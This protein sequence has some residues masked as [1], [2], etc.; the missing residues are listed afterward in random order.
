MSPL[1]R[2]TVL[3]GGGVSLAAAAG[4]GLA[5]SRESAPV[6][7]PDTTDTAPED[8]ALR[9]AALSDE[10]RLVT[11][12][13]ETAN[14]ITATEGPDASAKLVVLA[15]LNH[16][17]EHVTFLKSEAGTL[18]RAV[19]SALLRE[20]LASSLGQDD[21]QRL[22]QDP[23]PSLDPSPLQS[24][25]S[26]PSESAKPSP[27]PAPTSAR[28]SPAPSPSPSPTPPPMPTFRPP[29]AKPTT[30]TEPVRALLNG[31]IAA[32]RMATRNRTSDF[33]AAGSDLARVL[34]S[35][36]AAG[37]VHIDLLSTIGP[38]T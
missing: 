4:V 32:E 18:P 23:I 8:G 37:A 29:P 24:E 30:L 5:M 1:S 33:L 21:V 12:A 35:L 16:H 2:R 31:L 36:A 38:V 3:L 28:P 34:A 15:L 9:A 25:S 6:T 17:T 13:R 14:A 20:N 22:R 7:T 10:E 19:T 27:S 26:K 11:K